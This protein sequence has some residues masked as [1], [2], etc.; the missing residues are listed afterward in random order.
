[1]AKTRMEF[2]RQA[3]KWVGCNE[4]DGSFKPI[5]DLYNQHRPLARGYKVKYTDEW[6]AT[7]VSAVAIYTEMTDIIPTECGC[8]EMIKK[9][10]ALGCWDEN[11]AL[12][13][14]A[15]DIIFYGWKD[16]GK[17]DYKGH[18]DHVGI[19][20]NVA[21][22][23]I[24]VIEGNYAESVKRREIPING[25]YIRGFGRPNYK[26]V[27]V[28]PT[29][30]PKKPP[31]QEAQNTPTLT[32]VGYATNIDKSLS[33][34]YTVTTDLNMRHGA[35]TIHRVMKVLPKGQVVH[36]YGY[37]SIAINGK[38]WLYVKTTLDGVTYNGFCS[39]AYLQKK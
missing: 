13:P 21:N 11:D 23:I 4:K 32:A 9:F 15:G 10:Q 25:Q 5:I 28:E 14:A 39:K 29:P 2:V 34:E 8:D 31:I 22:G 33:G 7:F 17:G 24:Y 6:C 1:M 18:S 26:G 27:D 12:A 30:S 3:Q 38:Q 36:C 16:T 35:G 19:V 20:E 37:Y